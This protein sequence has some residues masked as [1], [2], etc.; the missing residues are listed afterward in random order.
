M[1]AS[2]CQNVVLLVEQNA[3]SAGEGKL[4]RTAG[5][6]IRPPCSP[7]IPSSSSISAAR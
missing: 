4:Y 3:N 1:E 7:A 6:F 5:L 2:S